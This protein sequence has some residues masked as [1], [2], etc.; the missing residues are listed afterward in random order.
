MKNVL[1]ILFFIPVVMYSQ[2]SGYPINQRNVVTGYQTTAEGV[3]YRG[4][5]TPTF[6]PVKRFGTYMY[7]DTLTSNIFMYIDSAKGWRVMAPDS[8]VYDSVQQRLSLKH[9]NQ[10]RFRMYRDTTLKGSN[11]QASPLRVDTTIIA[12]KYDISNIANYN[13][14]NA[15]TGTVG[16]IQKSTNTSVIG[17]S[18]LY[19]SNNRIGLNTTTDTARFTINN[20]N[21]TFPALNIRSGNPVSSSVNTLINVDMQPQQ[22]DQVN[23]GLKLYQ[24][25]S[26]EGSSIGIGIN[27]NARNTVYGVSSSVSKNWSGNSLFGDAIGIYGSATTDSPY[28]F[29]YGGYFK[30]DT[31]QGVGYGVFIQTTT[32]K[33][34][35]TVIPLAIKHNNTEL[36]RMTSSGRLGIGTTA[37]E[38]ALHVNGDAIL[39]SVW[40]PGGGDGIT[41][42]YWSNPTVKTIYINIDHNGDAGGA[43]LNWS[44]NSTNKSLVFRQSSDGVNFT[45]RARFDNTGRFG[46]N[47][48]NPTNILHVAGSV[49]IDTLRSDLT[50]TRLVGADANGTLIP[51]TAS[52][53]GNVLPSGNLYTTNGSIPSATNREVT[54][55]SNSLVKFLETATK[56]TNV[57]GGSVLFQSSASNTLEANTS[58]LF[59]SS[60]TPNG[61]SSV[62][63]SAGQIGL[64]GN[65]G[66][67]LVTPGLFVTAD[68][69]VGFTASSTGTSD[70][71]VFKTATTN[72]LK[73]V[74]KMPLNLLTN[75]IT[76]TSGVVS[77]SL[78]YF[79]QG[80]PTLTSSVTPEHTLTIPAG[81]EIR[82]MTVFGN[83]TVL[84]P[85]NEFVLNINNTANSATVWFMT[86]VYDVNSGAYIDSDAYGITHI[87]T[88]ATNITRLVFPNMNVFS[89]TGFRILMR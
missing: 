20:W 47:T 33:L 55:P 21:S 27:L 78:S 40:S 85:S 16:Y 50:A 31:T 3:F 26:S 32:P 54:V 39:N 77:I 12:T 14:G 72:E 63:L 35:G 41:A 76:L 8:L 48:Q 80:T 83:S 42:S 24:S 82:T 1:W 36:I 56:F 58:G 7:V 75:N 87:Q 46:I 17:N 44:S 53:S 5:T 86:Q 45:E 22:V 10:V 11:T 66:E 30:N 60:S 49:R 68:N 23:T 61:N 84:T 2:N 73:A 13:I 9:N 65:T 43:Q 51:V 64:Y 4:D 34:S 37:P 28:G 62:Q 18:I 19:E 57:K 69:K 81:V 89:T 70:S 88:A 79:G 25:S 67:N 38:G 6:T 15:L 59:R 29:S 74:A 52:M 71:I